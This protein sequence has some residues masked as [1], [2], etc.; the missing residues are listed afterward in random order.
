M[1]QKLTKLTTRVLA[2]LF[3]MFAT[4][5]A[6]ADG[7][8]LAET[9]GY[10]TSTKALAFADTSLTLDDLGST[11]Y[12]RARLAGGNVDYNGAETMAFLLTDATDATKKTYQFQS[13]DGDYTKSVTVEFTVGE[14]GIYAQAK[15]AYYGD[16]N[17]FGT[18]LTNA[19]TL[20][21]NATSK[22]Y[23]LYDLKLVTPLGASD[24]INVNFT[25]G[26]ALSSDSVCIGAG[27]WIVPY[28]SWNNLQAVDSVDNTPA[29][30]TI[31]LQSSEQVTVTLTGTRGSW[32]HDNLSATRDLQHGYIDET[33]TQG[34]QNPTVTVTDIPYAFYKVIVFAA[35][36]TENAQFGYVTINGVDYTSNYSSTSSAFSENYSTK[37]GNSNWGHAGKSNKATGLAEGINYLVSPITSGTTAT[38]VGHRVSDTVR[39]CI[40]AIQIV[41]VSNVFSATGGGTLDITDTN[42]WSGGVVPDGDVEIYVSGNTTINVD[43]AKTFGTVNIWGS[44]TLTLSGSSAITASNVTVGGGV[45]LKTSSANL[46]APVVLTTQ[47]TSVLDINAACTWARAISGAG[48]VQVT[49][50]GETTLS[51]NN[52]FTGGLSIAAGATVKETG[53]KGYG[54]TNGYDGS[55]YISGTLDVASS[56]NNLNTVNLQGGKMTNTGS[57]LNENHTQFPTISLYSNSEIEVP[58]GKIWYMISGSWGATTLSIGNS[59]L[60]KSGGGEW[61]LYGTTLNSNGGTLNISEGTVVLAKKNS[62]S[63]APVLGGA[64]KTLTKSGTGWLT[65]QNT[66]IYGTINV[67]G[68]RL[69]ANSNSSCD[70]AIIN[71]SSGASLD[72]STIRTG[73]TLS[74]ESGSELVLDELASDDG[75][76]TF[77][78]AEGS[79]A[80]SVR[81]Y[82][83]N[84]S[85][86]GT[87]VVDGTTMTVTYTSSTSGNVCWY[88][89]EFNGNLN[90]SGS[91]GAQ[92]MGSDSNTASDY[93]DGSMRYTAST[94]WRGDIGFSTASSW[95]VAIR[96]TVPKQEN[97]VVVGFGSG[98]S[99]AIVLAAGAPDESGEY[100]KMNLLYYTSS[101]ANVGYTLI[102]E[103]SVANAATTQH[104]YVF[105]VA[106]SKISVYCDGTK[107]VDE[108][109]LPGSIVNGVQLGSILNQIPGAWYPV[110]NGPLKHANTLTGDAKTDARIDFLRVYN[111]ALGPNL[112]SQLWEENP[113]IKVYTRTVSGDVDWSTTGAWTLNNASTDWANAATAQAIVTVSEDTAL[114]LPSTLSADS[115]RFDIATGKVLT[116]IAAEGGSTVSAPEGL[117]AN[118]GTLALSGTFA[119]PVISGTASV[120]IADNA[121]VT[122]AGN[123]NVLNSGGLA[124]G[125]GATLYP[126]TYTIPSV[127]GGATSEVVYEGRVPQS[128]AGWTE[129]ATW[130]GTVTVKTASNDYYE[131]NNFNLNNYGHLGSTVKFSGI[132]GYL[133]TGV[134]SELNV[135]FEVENKGSL[136]GFYYSNGNGSDIIKIAK[137]KGSG[138]LSTGN[139]GNGGIVWIGDVSKFSGNMTLAAKQINIG[140]DAPTS[141]DSSAKG[142]KL[143]LQAG[144]VITVD[145][146]WT[147]SAGFTIDGEAITTAAASAFSGTVK[148][149]GRITANA[150][151]TTAPTFVSD[152]WTGE[153]VIKWAISS[154]ELNLNRYGITGSTVVLGAEMGGSA[155]VSPNVSF[156]PS[157]RLDAKMSIMNGN[158]G[159]I[160]TFA[161]VTGSGD[162]YIYKYYSGTQTQKISNLTD[163]TGKLETNGSQQFQIVN[164]KTTK[165]PVFGEVLVRTA[166]TCTF[167]SFDAITLN[168]ESVKLA[169]LTRN[170]VRGIYMVAASR[171]VNSSPVY[172]ATLEDAALAALS[173]GEDTFTIVN[174]AAGTEL[175]GWDYAEGTFTRNDI[176]AYNVTT[177]TSYRTLVDALSDAEAG[178]TIKLVCAN[179]EDVVLPSGVTLDCGYYAYTGTLGGAGRIVSKTPDSKPEA[180]VTDGVDKWVGT[181]VC[182]WDPAGDSNYIE[183]KSYGTIN[184]VVE[185]TGMTAGYLKGDGGGHP[186]VTTT[187]KLSGNVTISN[188]DGHSTQWTGNLMT[189]ARLTGSGNLNLP[190]ESGYSYINYK[191]SSIDASYGGQISVGGNGQL[192]VGAVDFDSALSVPTS[193]GSCIIPINL[194][195]SRAAVRTLPVDLTVG[196][197]STGKKLLFDTLDETSG[198]YLAVASVTENETTS[199]YSTLAAAKAAVGNTSVTINLLADTNES[200]ELAYGQ[201]LNTGSTTYTGTVS[202]SDSSAKIVQDGSTTYK[203]V[204]G[205]IFSVY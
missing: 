172:Y 103:I 97:T 132:K 38:I 204:Y 86:S 166:N 47:F 101:G 44:G 130:T 128:G 188:G 186:N 163:Y 198:L 93:Y 16:P 87:A 9:G 162:L 17:A 129:T 111:T 131:V 136:S 49:G 149:S 141:N 32:K 59:T 183:I 13:M 42:N 152:N 46:V 114:T 62:G 99:Q 191:I 72:I 5:S 110:N 102:R 122:L 91:A 153:Y 193:G 15:G 135:Q 85:K 120:K 34:K 171:T 84:D 104:L 54:G 94:A 173:A 100:N 146:T 116:L 82:N 52:T 36:D 115:I 55:I 3:A 43:A 68:G 11:Y 60:T 168:N 45:T 48:Y 147:A 12:L 18:K 189:I 185:L 199:Y 10:V 196:N 178:Q 1:M 139:A 64:S 76:I 24:S 192:E 121:T 113:S 88:D 195:Y 53:N 157:L 89:Y 127:T 117:I 109:S 205:T 175:E 126:K 4:G 81:L 155:Y 21:E 160:A 138:T 148:G 33:S 98:N 73:V 63:T 57:S 158:S 22:G 180:F 71:V 66:T 20:V 169:I 29:S 41:K 133:M 167:S 144:S 137:L 35:T 39:G 19:G 174:S 145:N 105:S 187:V 56:G 140:G 28:S 151:P 83:G 61:K 190:K 194:T 23:A 96:C 25:H 177:D 79:S 125:D 119:L 8:S 143:I 70:S 124:I 26:T 6:W 27:D 134:P 90:S 161:E 108:V 7:E 14:D 107:L 92:E 67:T 201:V 118:G 65:C 74:F 40:A 77:T 95:S 123:L 2:T 203:V 30:A 200:V 170:G 75:E 31:T 164:I 159:G 37:T 51:A 165:A 50:A 154:G 197:V 156:L 78:V 142:G 184:S 176:V 181:F 179:D 112:L 58:S 80:P 182:D 150:W 202:A 106:D 69:T